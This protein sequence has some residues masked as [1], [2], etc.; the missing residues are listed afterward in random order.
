MTR[1]CSESSVRTTLEGVIRSECALKGVIQDTLCVGFLVREKAKLI[2]RQSDKILNA[3]TLQRGGKQF[4]LGYTPAT[5]M[6]GKGVEL[7]RKTGGE[8][9]GAPQEDW[10]GRVW[11]SSGRDHANKSTYIYGSMVA[12]TNLAEG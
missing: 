3:I 2:K 5:M 8:G 10:W 7:P 12:T 4:L 6:V 1:V 11:S 9:C